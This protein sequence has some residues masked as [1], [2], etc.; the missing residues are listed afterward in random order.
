MQYYTLYT[1]SD[2]V[3]SGSARGQLC[4]HSATRSAQTWY[5]IGLG[6]LYVYINSPVTVNLKCCGKVKYL[7]YFLISSCHCHFWHNVFKK[8]KI[9]HLSFFHPLLHVFIHV[10]LFVCFVN[11]TGVYLTKHWVSLNNMIV[12]CCGK[13]V[14]NILNIIIV[15]TN[16][17]K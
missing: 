11:A 10:H 13:T 4:S 15:L 7:Y 14:L 5:R 9:L 16:C 3:M 8:F 1:Y 17:T 2:V 12:S 6:S